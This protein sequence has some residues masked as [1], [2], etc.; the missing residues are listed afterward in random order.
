MT[1]VDGRRAS[2][3]K[4][5]SNI[6]GFDCGKAQHLCVI[7]TNAMT[8]IRIDMAFGAKLYLG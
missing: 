7:A 8:Y 3:E 4:L 6:L 2:N 1:M 5:D